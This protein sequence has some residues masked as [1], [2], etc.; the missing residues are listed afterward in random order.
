MTISVGGQPDPERE[1]KVAF[2]DQ[3]HFSGVTKHSHFQKASSNLAFIT[4]EK[5]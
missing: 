3:L 2:E 1:R 5:K 4:K